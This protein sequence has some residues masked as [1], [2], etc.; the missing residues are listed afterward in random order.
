MWNFSYIYVGH[1]LIVFKEYSKETEKQT[2]R[3]GDRE[4]GN[5]SGLRMGCM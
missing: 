4:S 5:V 1:S 3:Y 2:Q